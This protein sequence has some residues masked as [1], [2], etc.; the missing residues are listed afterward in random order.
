VRAA[1][2]G[3]PANPHTFLTNIAA[4]PL[5]ATVAALAL[6]AQEQIATF[7]ESDGTVV[8]DPDGAGPFFEVPIAGPLPEG[9]NF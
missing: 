1:V 6:A 9:L 2:P 5:P 3:A 8:I 4:P 7:F